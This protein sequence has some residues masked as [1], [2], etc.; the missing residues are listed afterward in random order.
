MNDEALPASGPSQDCEP[1]PKRV[2][3]VGI[4]SSAGGVH[5][6]QQFFESLPDEVDA[7][8]VV[9]VH[10]DPVHQ[11]ELPAIL[12]ARTRMPVAQV[13]GRV[14]L[15]ARHVYVIPPN[16]QLFVTDHHLGIA[17]FDE[18]RWQRAPIDLFFRSLA[19]QRGDDFAIVL[20]GAGSD[21]ALGIKAVKEA[22][23]I[24]LVQD[25]EE[26]EYG[27]M[28]RSAMATG[29]A[30]FVLPVREIAARLPEL[31]ANR[32]LVPPEPEDEADAD[33]MRR[34]LSHLLVRTGH[35]F[36]SY[37]KSTVRRRIARRMQVRRAA[38]MN[39]Y[40]SILRE[41]SEEAQALLADLLISVTTFFRDSAAFERVA[42]LAVPSLFEDKGA[43][44]AIRVWVPGCATGEEAYS[45]AML[46]LEEAGRHNIRCPIQ[47]FASDLDDAALAT[48]R[49]GRYPLAIEADM[50]EERLKRFFTRETDHYRVTRDLRD[51]VLFARHSLLRDPPFSRVDLISCRN[52]L[53]YLERPL[54]QQVCATF[55]FALNPSGY[56]FLGAS[57]SA[58]SPTGMFRPLDREAR[59]YQRL[60]APT[61]GG[62]RA[63]IG[64]VTFG[65]E[66]LSARTPS[67]FR[68]T[69]DDAMHREA[70]ERFAP[71]S[72][73]VDESF[74]VAHLSETAGRYLQPPG[75]A[76]VND[77]TQ[78][79]REELRTDLRAALHATFGR[80]ESA[81]S[82][83]IA[84]R[85]NGSARRVYLQARPI[86][87]PKGARS[88]L[89]LFLEGASLGDDATDAAQ[90]EERATDA[91]VW[92]LQQELQYT[93]S[94]LRT[95]RE[96]YEG[97]FEELRAANEELQ[98]INEEYR[99]TGEELET[100]K[101]EL[102]S[103]NEELQT[104]N[105]ELKAKL[106][107]VSRSHSDIQNLM[108]ATDVGILFLDTDLRIKRFTARVAD[109][110][111]IAAGD[112]GRS[113]TDFTHSLEY[114]S[115]AQDAR[116]LLCDL[117][118]IERE[119]RSRNG[120]WHLLRMRPYRTE[121]NK[122]DGVVVTLVNIGELRR[123]RDALREGEARMRAVIDGVADAIVTIDEHG[124]IQS[125]NAAT[126]RMFGYSAEE[127]SGR[128]V[129]ALVASPHDGL[130]AGYLER[131]MRTGESG[132]MGRTREVN[133]RRKDGSVFPLELTIS[134]IQHG[135][136]RLFIGF[137][138]DLSERRQ[139][140]ARLNR[141][142]SNR[143]DTMADM[144]TALAHEINQPLA[145]A[146]NYVSAARHMLGAKAESSVPAVDEALEKAASQMLRAGQI[147]SHL[148][149]FMGR[150]EPNKLEQSLHD[151]IRSACELV[152]PAAR[153]AE[154]Q[155]AL[156]LDAAEDAVL[157]DRVQIEQAIVNL[158]RNA[159]EA[160]SGQE[161]E[162]KLTIS[163]S[164]EN[165][166]IRTDITDTGTGVS[167][168][169]YAELFVPFTSTKATGLGVGLSISRSIIEAHYG[170][171]WAEA[172]PGGGAKFSFTLPLARLESA[173]E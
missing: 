112:E 41:S 7:A 48:G 148:R 122:I 99:S 154:V 133:G 24:I 19:A 107:D 51:A 96:E 94:Q 141:L 76:L 137:A 63:R 56:L 88:A 86:T 159:I 106:D 36:S 114:G 155:V 59:L 120:D 143:L 110:F 117:A 153:E 43:A 129:D 132:I 139:F 50:T 47:V 92:Q 90:I 38:T 168:S 70:L 64:A 144:A 134:E 109:L 57:E 104:V 135:G 72:V 172:N 20:S 81:L 111:N 33:A 95:S 13:S 16:R 126:T 136:E 105:A 170:S 15:E 12:A 30:D 118:S 128:D 166:M 79:V 35:D 149:E 162:R 5:A 151:L 142:H 173:S 31:I 78:L 167:P 67:P 158:S 68:A 62:L 22:G 55:H 11:S 28:P 1:A 3:T 60:P 65:L 125:V 145:A 87:D 21:G 61:D 66:P 6:L 46:L 115:L 130:H 18:P 171:I 98:S 23:G 157:A 91:E 113:I 83:P 8:F 25:P 152:T 140:E 97:A 14:P 80:N 82:G 163:T 34:I 85:F 150:G 123:V 116:G 39:D 165:D 89:V 164:L 102:Q 138:R 108:D 73:L 53:I 49:E 101:E 84:V 29:L 124:A 45:I 169:A 10:L 74:R 147:I 119:V 17:E 58:D 4:G 75:G 9:V 100:S 69:L 131:Y 40:L 27:S 160:M 127:L 156:R 42:A 54:Q 146:S 71:P 77:V 93:Q 32:D 26:A 44:D 161:G 103:I 121:E 2:P 52:L 37:R